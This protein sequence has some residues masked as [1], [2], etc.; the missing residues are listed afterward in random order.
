MRHLSG[1]ATAEA[2]EYP[3]TDPPRASDAQG[4]RS[5]TT[6]SASSRPRRVST[7][8]RPLARPR[9]SPR[10][11]QARHRG[12][13]GVVEHAPGRARRASRDLEQHPLHPPV[14]ASSTSRA[15]A[16][17]T[18]RAEPVGVR[19]GV[20]DVP[21]PHA[22][23]VGVRARPDAPPVRPGPVAEVVPAPRAVVPR[24]VGHL[25]P[26]RARRRR[27]ARRRAGTCPRGR[28]RRA[29]AARRAARARASAVPSSTI[30]E[31]AET[32]SGSHASAASSDVAQS[33]ERLPRRAVDEVQADLLEARL[34]A[35]TATTP[36]T[37][38]GS[39]VR[40]SVAST[41]GTADCI[42]NEI[43]LKPPSRSRSRSR[44]VDAVGVGLGRHLGV[45]GQPELGVD[46]GDAP[47][48]GRRAAAA[49][50]CRRR[51]RPSRPAG[52]RR[53]A[54]ARASRTSAIAWSGV[55]LPGTTPAARA[56]R[57]CRC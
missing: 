21:P 12:A 18:P 16:G 13:A 25:V 44:R 51:R 20:L 40:S 37:R 54:P 30:R 28:P 15:C 11:D 1:P 22:A 34:R 49:S 27:A 23:D 2:Y 47:R 35:P 33:A 3:F 6:A 17:L 24:P 9:R 8:G 50:A 38:S 19:R 46:R 43:R 7:S 45:G 39:C 14:S 52:L 32:W 36:G 4:S 10:V 29:S 53:R 55:R 48:P 26:V 5:R 31:Y 42:P 56:P 41:C 57:R